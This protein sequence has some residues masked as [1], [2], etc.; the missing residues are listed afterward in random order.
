MY[1]G[2][3][4]NVLWY[5]RTGF[6]RREIEN[7]QALCMYIYDIYRVLLCAYILQGEYSHSA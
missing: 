2:T 6:G 3:L 7:M 1:F 4:E 5:S